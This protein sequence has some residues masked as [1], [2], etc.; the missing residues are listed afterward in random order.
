ML[1]PAVCSLIYRE[2]DL[3]VFVASAL[4]TSFVGF[5]LERWTKTPEGIEELERRDGFLIASMCWFSAAVFGAVPYMLYGVFTNPVD[6]FFESVAGF[7]TTGASVLTNIEVFPHGILFWRNFTQWLGGMGMIV[8]GI[9]IL[10]RLA[11]GGMQLMSLEAPGPTT[12][13]ITPRIAE[14]AKKLWGVYLIFSALQAILLFFAGMSLYDSVVHTFTTMSTGGFSPKNL[15]IAAYGSPIIE[16]IIT[17]FMFIAGANFV[18]HY[19]L[20]RG[21]FK[22]LLTDPEF[23]FYFFLNVV[24]ILLVSLELWMRVYPSFIQALRF[25]SFQVVSIGT[26]TGYATDNFDMWPPLSK[27][28]LFLLM[29]LGG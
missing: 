25:S 28:L 15:S 7:T 3:W 1:V 20:F 5:V 21:D 9:A 17:V 29:F 16:V 11:V 2:N 14:T 8:L 22:R 12:E 26:T 10:P 13:R 18:L 4:C 6:A 23:R 24:A 27:W 19:A